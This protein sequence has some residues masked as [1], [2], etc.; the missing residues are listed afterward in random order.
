MKFVRNL[1]R[2]K[3]R[4][5]IK[6][7]RARLEG[8]YPSTAPILEHI[9]ELN[10]W[11]KSV[12]GRIGDLNTYLRART[13]HTEDHV[14]ELFRTIERIRVSV[15]ALSRAEAVRAEAS[16]AWHADVLVAITDKKHPKRRRNAKRT[17]R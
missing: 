15:E 1:F 12:D 9:T 17:G 7:L 5:D 14:H 4:A 16:L 10:Q 8:L 13:Q 3:V 6:E 11:S 2:S